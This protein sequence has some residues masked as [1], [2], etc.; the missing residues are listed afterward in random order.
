VISRELILVHA[1]QRA[2]APATRA[3]VQLI[4]A[5]IEQLL[6]SGAWLGRV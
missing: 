2:Q 5:H 6:E 4:R 1:P 3:V